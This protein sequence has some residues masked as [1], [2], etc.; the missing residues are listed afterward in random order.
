MTVEDHIFALKLK[1]Q[2]LGPL[3][4]E[5][6][7]LI[8]SKM[9][10]K[11]VK[12]NESFVRTEGQL[13]YIASGLFKEYTAMDRERP[14]ILNFINPH[15]AIISRKYNKHHY[16]KAALNTCVYYWDFE[17]LL[18]IYH[19]FKELKPIYDAFCQEYDAACAFRQQL[20]E[21]PKTDD[22]IRKFLTRFPD[23]LITI[24]KKD[25]A[26]YLNVSYH[27]FIHVY[28]GME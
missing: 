5:A 6:W 24:K 15:T 27:H 28:N 11:T 21:I 14:A 8:L 25:I 23:T 7:Q 22:R 10:Y 13:T 26:N 4:H 1:I 16:L 17:S 3:R 12:V 9:Q 20:L 2:S 19:E 18:L